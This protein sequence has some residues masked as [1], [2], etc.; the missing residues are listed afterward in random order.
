MSREVEEARAG[1]SLSGPS[2]RRLVLATATAGGLAGACSDLA[3]SPQPS[4]ASLSIV[5]ADTLVTVGD[6]VAFRVVV[7]DETGTPMRAPPSWTRPVWS[8]ANSD[9]IRMLDDGRGVAA[10]PADTNVTV[11][12]AGLAART[13]LRVNPRQARLSA[14]AH[15]VT[16]GI[17][18]RA[19]S[20]PLI[21]GRDAL[22]RVFATTDQEAYFDLEVRATLF[23]SDG[24]RFPLPMR[25]AARVV[26]TSVDEGDLDL[27]FNGPVPAAMISPGTTMIVELDPER[28]IELSP[29]SEPRIPP[30]GRIHLDIRRVPPL[31]LT[32]VPV[33]NSLDPDG[34]IVDAV[35][36]LDADS[37][38]LHLARSVLPIRS[39]NVSVREPYATSV[40]LTKATAWVR[41]LE[42]L[43]LLY[44]TERIRGYFYGALL[45]SA[46][47]ARTGIG[48]IALESIA[49]G[50]LNGQVIAHE[51]GHNMSLKHAPCGGATAPDE[52]FPYRDGAVG[53]WGYDFRAK[54]IVFPALYKDVMGYCTPAWGS[55][56]HFKRALAF[57]LENETATAAPPPSRTKSLLLWGNTGRGPGAEPRLEPA[58]VA[59]AYPSLPERPGP[60]RLDGVG[61]GGERLFSYSFD[62]AEDEFGGAPFAFAVPLDPS[63]EAALAEVVLSGPDGGFRLKRSGASPVGLVRDP[64]TGR[65]RAVLRDWFGQY[66]SWLEPGLEI[67]ASDGIPGPAHQR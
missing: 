26:P 46:K 63:W 40:D 44:R 14:P 19:G 3:F 12:I 56:Y 45:P 47:A 62:P 4:P 30:V 8:A 21:A 5:P 32:V 28:T 66:P 27:S 7:L 48:Y 16:Q 53:V 43:T 58:F 65:V 41:L 54:R 42:E 37:E 20:V 13:A 23:R 52:H 15:Y 36:G 39:V 67:V 25:S 22:V 9:A 10:K 61:G 6:T 34:E 11:E 24:L 33:V 18:D 31:D 38:H 57:R 64:V 17:Q 1:G 35:R 59:D 50:L 2:V 51:L 60:Y 55:D 49:A 29:D